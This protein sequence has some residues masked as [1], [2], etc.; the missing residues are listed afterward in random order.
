MSILARR[1]IDEL[2]EEAASTEP[3]PG[4]GSVT[5]LCGMLG[6]S[7]VL[8]AL[9]ISL[10]HRDD[11]ADFVAADASLAALAA[12]ISADA[13]AD[14]ESFSAFIAALRLPKGS[15]DEAE[16]RKAKLQEAAVASTEAGLAAL[17][18]AVRAMAQARELAPVINQTMAPDLTAGLALL[19]VLHLNAVHNAE[20]NLA[21]VKAIDVHAALSARLER[22]KGA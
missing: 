15:P 8:K 2:F 14:A 21:S 16:A 7:L 3:A 6:V 5:A 19:Q 4:G 20:A 9:R 22:L 13:D 12:Q 11:G 18:H 17:E 10:K 1:P